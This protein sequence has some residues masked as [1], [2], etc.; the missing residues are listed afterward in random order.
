MKRKP[1][2]PRTYTLLDVMTASPTE[3][4]PTPKRLH[5][6]TPGAPAGAPAGMQR[7]AAPSQIE[8]QRSDAGKKKRKRH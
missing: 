3:P 2:H 5:Q 4:T 1:T 6:L 7:V 8:A